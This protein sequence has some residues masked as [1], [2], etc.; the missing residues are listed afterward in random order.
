MICLSKADERSL[1]HLSFNQSPPALS[2]IQ[3]TCQDLNGI[4]NLREHVASDQDDGSICGT[5]GQDALDDSLHHTC[6]SPERLTKPVEAGQWVNG[7][8][9]PL[10]Q[11]IL[12]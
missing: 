10:S 2:A 4:T 3:T 5:L 8:G 11:L 9:I 6:W 12:L 7:M 1:R